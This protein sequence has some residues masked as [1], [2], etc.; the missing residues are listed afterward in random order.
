MLRG[1]LEAQG[2]WHL[3]KNIHRGV[4]DVAVTP[5]WGQQAPLAEG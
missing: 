5:Q 4:A 3:E 2:L 1:L